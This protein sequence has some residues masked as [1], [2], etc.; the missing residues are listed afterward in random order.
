MNIS[1]IYMIIASFFFALS[2]NIRADSINIIGPLASLLSIEI[3][4]VILLLPLCIFLY[5]NNSNIGPLYI[6][7]KGYILKTLTNNFFAAFCLVISLLLLNMAF[8]INK[9]SRIPINIGILTS[10]LSLGFLFSI[11]INII[12]NVYKK[13]PNNISKYEIFGSLLIIGGVI[14]IAMSK[15]KA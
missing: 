13:I 12:N 11:I 10:I 15:T 2:D 14:V 4:I 1:F 6:P 7:N 9:K 8:Y 5:L 3:I